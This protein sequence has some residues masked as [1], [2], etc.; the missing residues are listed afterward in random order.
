MDLTIIGF[1]I[2]VVGIVLQLSDAFPEHRETRKVIVLLSLGV[3][4]G[5]GAS[6]LLGAKYD[7]QGNVDAK[8]AL[9]YG[10]AGLAALFGVLAVI[11]GDEKR[12]EAAIALAL[13]TGT[14]FL[15]SGLAIGM[16][17]IG[18]HPVYS[19]DEIM[20]LAKSAEAR[21]QYET[22]IDRL[23]EVLSRVNEDSAKQG[24]AERI[25]RLQIAQAAGPLPPK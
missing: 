4:V 16:G 23:E 21:G 11:V 14:V 20:L 12:R 9:L 1:V 22:A 10:L 8:F 5:I 24:L 2:A 6:A 13:A 17:S 15:F 19:T 25:K 7:I 18:P 3:F